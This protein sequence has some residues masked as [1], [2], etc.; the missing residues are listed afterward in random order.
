MQ[1]N[2]LRPATRN[3]Y[4]YTCANILACDKINVEKHQSSEEQLPEEKEM[5]NA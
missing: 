2:T 3:A 1:Y 5:Y 4:K